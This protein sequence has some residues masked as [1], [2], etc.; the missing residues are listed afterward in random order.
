MSVVSLVSAQK[1]LI[2]EIV[3]LLTQ[4]GRDFSENIIVFPGK[5]P[6]HALRKKLAQRV[7]GSFIPPRIFSID[8]FIDVLY[9][10][11]LKFSERTLEALDAAAVLHEIYLADTERIGGDHFTSFD[12]F[13]PLGVKIF[14]ELEELW[15]A[16]IPLSRVRDALSGITFSGLTSLLTFY[17]QFYSLADDRNFTTRS[18]KYRAVAT[19]IA[20]IDFSDRSKIIFAGFFAFTTSEKIIVKHFSSLDNVVQIFQNGPGIGNRL[21]ELGLSLEA[22]LQPSSQPSFSFY[23]SADTHGQVFAL[24]KKVDELKKQDGFSFDRTAIVLPAAETLFPVFHQ[25]LALIPDNEYNISLGYPLTRT[26]VYGFLDTLMELI[27]SKYEGRYSVSQYVKFVLHPYTKNI[28]YGSRSDITRILFNTIEELFLKEHSAGFFLLEELEGNASLFERAARRM[29]GMGESV[30][31]ESLKDHLISI[32]ANTLR[33][34]DTVENIGMFASTTT[35]VLSYI[36]VHSTAQLHPFFRP[37]AE[38]MVE[39]LDAVSTSLVCDRRF[40]E[41][42]EYVSF[43]RNYVAAAEVPFTGTPLHGLQVLGFL[44]TRNLQF[45][46][47]FILDANDDI[48]PGNKGHDVLLPMK[49]RETLGLS[50]YRDRERMAEYYFGVLL[51]G[52]KEVHFFFIQDGKKEK[53]RYVE[54]LLWEKEQREKTVDANGVLQTLRYRIQLANA[55]PAAIPKTESIV[56]SLKDFSFNATALDTY[57]K[58]QLRFY[59]G[60]VLQLREREEVSGELEQADVGIFVHAALAG[61]FRTLR[62]KKLEKDALN[63][64]TLERTIDELFTKEYG[65]NLLGSIYLLKK[66]IAS[67]VKD[68]LIYYQIP[69]LKENVTLLDLE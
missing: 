45:D 60:Y 20:T 34:F 14:G 3:P 35:G 33:M 38:A 7:G 61:Y 8:N 30:P 51:Q 39:C 36:N 19:N 68:F 31:A 59:Y 53:S 15:I 66:Q 69:V 54:K 26:P 42:I 17:E 41:F 50:T 64:S 24:T 37:F 47:V 12:S 16:N 28:R 11:K 22:P 32:H 55:L 6:A 67:H 25:T 58:C 13:L 44:E 56:S 63:V 49:L 29:A 5:R 52:A 62:N 65:S 18:M 46:R 43:L 23:R 10:D 27:I 57:L 40:D 1:N 21:K 4:T 9:R 2:D 48:L